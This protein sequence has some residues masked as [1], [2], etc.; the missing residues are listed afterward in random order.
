MDIL[1]HK[2]Q[3]Q[4]QYRDNFLEHYHRTGSLDWK[5]YPHPRNIQAPPGPG[6]D[7]SASRLMLIS[8]AGG[9]LPGEQEPFD[10]VDLLGDYSLRLIPMPTP[11]ETLAFAHDH[12]DHDAVEKDPQVLMPLRHL[13]ALAGEGLIGEMADSAVS[14][15]GYQ[16]DVG[17]VVDELIPPILETAAAAEI[18]TALLIPT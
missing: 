5:L 9:Y 1:E 13:E 17:R 16:P 18:D 10:A 15:M 2:I 8:S 11:L 6:V 7:P 4:Q 12:Y 14:F 3:W